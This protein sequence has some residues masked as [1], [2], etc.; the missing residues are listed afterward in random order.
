MVRFWEASALIPLCLQET[1][2]PP[3]NRLLRE[4]RVIVTWWGSRVECTSAIA[5]AVHDRVLDAEREA[6]ARDLQDE[7]FRGLA[8]IAPTEEVRVQAE[9]LL[10]SHR[11]RAGDALQLG[12]ALVWARGTTRGRRFICLDDRLRAAARREG[13][14]VLP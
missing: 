11:L 14:T 13:F 2:S 4:D 3:I 7:L 5:R 8:E 12:A 10:A 6:E 9:R 1:V